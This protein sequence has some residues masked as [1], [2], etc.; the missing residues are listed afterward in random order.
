MAYDK[1]LAQLMRDDLAGEGTIGERKM[2]GGIAFML[3]GNM[4]AGV[5]SGGGMFRVG[6]ER[7]DRARQIEG[8]GPMEFT[9]R[10]MGGMVAASDE[11]MAD[12]DRRRALMALALENARS[13]PPK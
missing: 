4:V 8:T 2:F 5:H 13:L 1:G 6:K 7:Q 11:L 12:D 9:G 3:D 10:P